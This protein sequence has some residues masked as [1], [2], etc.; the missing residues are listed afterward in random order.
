MRRF[1]GLGIIA[2][3]AGALIACQPNQ[4]ASTTGDSAAAST[5]AAPPAAAPAGPTMVTVR[6]RDFVFDAPDQIPAGMTTFRFVNDGPGLHHLVVIR[7]DSAKTMADLQKA[8]QAPGPFPSWAV[9]MGGPN[10]TDPQTEGNGT[11]ELAAGNYVLAC[12]V[13]IPGGVP[14]FAKGMIRPLTVTAA[15]GPSAAPP[16][17]ALTLTLSSYK[18]DLSQPLTAGTHTI[19][20]ETSAGQPHEVVLLRLEPG[21]T[22][23]DILA[24]MP[25]MKGAPP[26]HAVGGATPS[27]LGHPVYFTVKLV[28]GRYV[29]VCFLPDDKD[30]K[31]H[32][33]HG[34]MQTVD[35]T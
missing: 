23:K 10:A 6:A 14:H 28:P 5:A 21:K 35:V 7:L 18:F 30:G 9:T 13:D 16:T 34:M 1:N 27:S 2:V 11:I 26:A 17:A 12:F 15:S 31:P 25:T 8:L 32:F 22:S 29:L 3:G 24:W 4:H 33:A 20:V 19:K